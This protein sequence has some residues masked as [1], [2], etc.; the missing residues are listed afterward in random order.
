MYRLAAARSGSGVASKLRANAC[1]LRVIQS[2]DSTATCC[3][4]PS[5]FL[6]VPKSMVAYHAGRGG[7]L[8]KMFK[9]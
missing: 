2:A 7:S 6:F 8:F 1:V 5:G 4:L 3:D 9:S